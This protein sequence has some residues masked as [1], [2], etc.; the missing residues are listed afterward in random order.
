VE[1]ASLQIWDA[2]LL[3][4]YSMLNE[5]IAIA[6]NQKTDQPHDRKI[7]VT[8]PKLTIATKRRIKTEQKHHA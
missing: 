1:Q 5:E 6:I 2:S 7:S 8:M 4:I 3:V